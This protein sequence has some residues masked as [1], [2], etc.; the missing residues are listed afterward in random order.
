MG[1]YQ[2][3][4]WLV[5]HYI[6]LNMTTR[7]MAK[8]LGCSYKTI[9]Y[10]MKKH[11]VRIRYGSE[12]KKGRPSVA[13]SLS[14]MGDKNPMFRKCGEAHH[15][16]GKHHKEESIR[17]GA[18]ARRGK[19]WGHHTEEAKRKIALAQCGEKSRLWLGGISDEEHGPE[20]NMRLR[21]DIRFRDGFICRECGIKENGKKH[22]VH[23]INYEKKDNSP[24]NLISLC[25][26]CHS[27]TNFNRNDWKEYFSG[28]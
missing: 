7:E 11:G 25:R 26:S 9:L 18:D 28:G 20:F 17:R 16:F 12:A 5:H 14:K 15:F 10:W 8:I 22:D 21:K 24:D 6:E 1:S 4:D 19:K 23:H 27:K 2:D 3:A 13:M